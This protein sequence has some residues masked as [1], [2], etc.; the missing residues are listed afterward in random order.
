M[1]KTLGCIGCGNMGTAI[2]RGLAGRDGLRLLGSDLDTARLERLK[3]EIGLEPVGPV[4]EIAKQSDYLL[5]AVKPHQVRELLKGISPHL[6]RNVA[7][8]S[9][10][11]GLTQKQLKDWSSGSC[12]VVRVMPNTPA[13]VAKGVFALCLEDPD[14]SKDQRAF[15]LDM[16]T[17]L[18]QV[19]ELPESMFDAFTAVAGSGPA[20]VFYFMEAVVEAAVA[21]GIPRGPATDMVK[22]LF[23]GSAALAEQSEEHLSVL[24]EMVTSPAGTTIA[25]TN[26]MDVRAVRGAI[27]DAVKASCARSKELGKE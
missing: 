10:A 27:I 5:V 13:M 3:K 25:A 18:G 14:L 8:I 6:S 26:L 21:L 15:V 11:A 20:Y 19:H 22:G 12:P 24:R 1:T 2:L 4:K 7:L 16:F 9:I 17:P 23:S